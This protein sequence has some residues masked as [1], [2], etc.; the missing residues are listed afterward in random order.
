MDG[1]P[2][3]I[4]LIDGRQIDVGQQRRDDTPLRG[5]RH[6][7]PKAALDHDVGFQ[8]GENEPQDL[9]ILDAATYALHQHMVIDGVETALDVAL[10]HI[11]GP[12]WTRG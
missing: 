12:R 9:A 4:S 1:N 2:A 6:R 8:E 5:A 3:F 10:D 11:A 7:M